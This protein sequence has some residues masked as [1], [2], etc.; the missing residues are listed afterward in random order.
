MRLGLAE[1]VAIEAGMVRISLQSSTVITT[2]Y[3][4]Y[5]SLKPLQKKISG[6]SNIRDHFDLNWL[7]FRVAFTYLLHLSAAQEVDADSWAFVT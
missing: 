1:R 7:T 4:S 2:S 5:N 3:T 6:G